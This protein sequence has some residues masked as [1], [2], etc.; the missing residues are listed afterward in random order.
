MPSFP[1]SPHCAVIPPSM[2]RLA[3]VMK[4]DRSLARKTTASAM[5]IGE[6]SLRSGTVFLI[7]RSKV[8]LPRRSEMDATISVSM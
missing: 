7:R 8:A 1:V 6:P 4:R 2:T 3:P 5:S